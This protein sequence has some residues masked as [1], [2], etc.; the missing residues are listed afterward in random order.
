MTERTQSQKKLD[1][2]L[3][4][5]LENIKGRNS[6]DGSLELEVRFGTKGFRKLTYIDYT[7]VVKILKSLQFRH[8]Q[9]EDFLR[10]TSEYVDP[11]TG[12]TKMSNIRTEVSGVGNISKYCKTDNIVDTNGGVFGTFEQKTLIRNNDDSLVYPVDFEDF[13]FRVSLQVEKKYNQGTGII[14]GV[15][16]KWSNN[17]K[18]FRLINR[19]TLIHDK[20]PLKVDLSIVRSS[21]KINRNYVPEY[22][23]TNSGVLESNIEYEIE[24]ELDG[25][26]IGY[27]TEYDTSE[28]I[29]YSLRKVIKYV[30][31]GLQGT[32]YPVS[33]REQKDIL[34]EYMVSLWNEKK[35]HFVKP[36]NFV[37]PSSY[38]LQMYNI[39][40]TEDTNSPNINNNYTVTDKADGDRKLLYISSNNKIYLIDTNMNVQYTGAIS[41]NDDLRRTIVDGEHILHN[42]EGKYINLYAAFDIYYLKGQDVRS[43]QFVPNENVDDKTMLNYRLPLMVNVIKNINAKSIVKGED[44]PIRIEK[45]TFYK[46]STES[47]IFEQCGIIL[48]KENDGLFEY[49]TDGLIFTPSSFAVGAKNDKDKAKMPIKT[50]WEHSFKWKPAIYNTI[51]FLISIKKLPSGDDFIGNLFKTGINANSNVQIEQYKTLVLRVGFDEKIHGYI[52]PCKNVL[53]DEL[54]NV[55]NPDEDEGYRPMQFYPTNPSDNDA[56][57]CNIM[58]KESSNGEKIMLTKEGEIIED[59]MIVEF[60]Y[61]KNN[62]NKWKWTPLRV[63]YDKT[64]EL[65]NGGNNF[66]N[67]YHVANGNWHSIHNPI[68]DDIIRSGS[69]INENIG[70]DDVY[71]NAVSGK[72]RT[73]SLRDFHNKFVKNLLIKNVSKPGQNLIDLAVGKAGDFPK[74]ISSKLNFVF[75]IDVAKDNIENRKDGACARYLNNKKKKQRIPKSLFVEGNSSVNIRNTEGIITEQGKKI[76]NAVFGKGAK[77]IKDLGK[78]VYNVYGIGSE[79]FNICSIQFAIHYMFQSKLTLHNFLRNVSETTKEGGYFIGTSYDGDK[80]FKKLVNKERGESEIL[81]EDDDKIWEV[82]K[83]YEY[84]K[85]SDDSSCLGYTIDVYQESINKKFPE[86]LVNY[87]YLTRLLENYGFTPLTDKEASEM[88][89]KK[90][91]GNFKEL[92][93]IMINEPE[94]D[95]KNKYSLAEFMTKNERTISFLNNYFIYKKRR[96][97]D[98][99]TI[100]KNAVSQTIDDEIDQQE[101]NT[102]INDIITETRIQ[103]ANEVTDSKTTTTKTKK[104]VTLAE[105]SEEKP[106]K[107]KIRRKINVSNTEN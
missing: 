48:Q 66:G 106:K 17:K 35:N 76:T 18:T 26:K 58:L 14:R 9:Q 61:E 67:A 4:L 75:G 98:A 54:P 69:G 74:W 39:M 27:G 31:S 81:M 41:D 11:K 49:N 16:D 47:S 84:D 64:A 95:R 44:V 6:S 90:S 89:F 21:R 2:L 30:L 99:E 88:G 38:T 15:I 80:I 87:N 93:D 37:G 79:G 73:K 43:K 78:G 19:T 46:S 13:N 5:Y 52:N 68:T 8:L 25:E 57:I 82:T 72:S 1:E 65:R 7:N 51:D 94:R 20:F 60:S 23:F 53:D 10:I 59:N 12:V 50:T 36:K 96:N 77:D 24:I 62:E 33:Y 3:N 71:Y 22:R 101:A 91:I 56:G 92:Y 45:K 103:S 85:F 63:R 40:P 42:K 29:A 34:N 28:K 55:N 107:K 104:K 86:F 70:D 32:N 100:A 105:N 102:K 83:Q 97:V